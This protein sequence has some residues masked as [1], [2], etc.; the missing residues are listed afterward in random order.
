MPQ[1]WF[2][3]DGFDVRF[4][5][6]ISGVRALAPRVRVMAIVDVLRFTNRGGRRGVARRNRASIRG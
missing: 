2:A 6:G 3:Q 5:W 1:S 4:E